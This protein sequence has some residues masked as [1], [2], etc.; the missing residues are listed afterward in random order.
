M[1][2]LVDQSAQTAVMETTAGDPFAMGAEDA[3][4]STYVKFKGAS[5]EYLAGQD[6]DVIDHGTQFV[7]DIFNAKWIWSF[8]WDGKVLETVDG[9]LREQP[10]LNKQMPDFLPDNDDVDMTLDEIKKMQKEDPANFRDG[11]SVQ[12]SFGMLPVDGTD[13]A[14]TMRLGGMV[15]LNAFDALRKAYSRRYKLEIG[16]DPVIEL[17]ANKYKSKIK[18]V[19]TRSAPVMKIVDWLSPE[20]LM[21]FAGENDADYADQ[22]PEAD[23]APAQLEAPAETAAEAPAEDKPAATGRAGRRGARGRNM[24]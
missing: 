21:S 23:E 16:K 17:T 7:A 19:G 13:E 20:D 15:S 11:W 10:L 8:W 5:G 18:G 4:S 1:N 2:A 6:E 9:L 14:H 3:G 12:A 24:G 22:A